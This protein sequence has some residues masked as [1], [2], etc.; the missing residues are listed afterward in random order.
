MPEGK[1]RNSFKIR[2]KAMLYV[3]EVTGF[4]MLST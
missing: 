1:V 2:E 3:S 4:V